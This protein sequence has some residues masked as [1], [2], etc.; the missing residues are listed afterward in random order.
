MRIGG[1]KIQGLQS[2]LQRTTGALSRALERLGTGSRIPSWRDDTALSSISTK[3]DSQVR[4]LN[5]SVQN[6]KEALALTEV[7]SSGIDQQIEIVQRMREIAVEAASSSLTQDE[8]NSLQTELQQLLGDYQRINSN[9][10]YN[11][12][13][14]LNGSKLNVGFEFSTPDTDLNSSFRINAG[15]GAFTRTS[16]LGSTGH[17]GIVVADL[18]ADGHDDL[19]EYNGRVR[20]GT[21]SGAFG[22]YQVAATFGASVTN[23]VV[24]DVTADGILDLVYAGSD[25]SAVAVGNGDGTFTD[26]LTLNATA[27]DYV[28]T[29][30]FDGDGDIDIVV[31]TTADLDNQIYLNTGAES[32]TFSIAYDLYNTGGYVDQGSYG[33]QSEDINSDGKT[34]LVYTTSSMVGFF[35]QMLTVYRLGTGQGTFGAPTV[36]NFGITGGSL[37]IGDVNND[38]RKDVVIGEDGAGYIFVQ[39]PN[40]GFT[41]IATSPSADKFE[42][43]DLNNDGLLDIAGNLSALNI[44]GGRFQNLAFDL[45][46]YDNYYA[47]T[48]LNSDGVI[49]FI[50]SDGNSMRLLQQRTSSRSALEKVDVRTAAK[51]EQLLGLLDSTLSSLQSGAASYSALHSRLD[52]Q[53]ASQSLMS[54]VFAD[55]KERMTSADL[56]LETAEVLRIQILQQAQMA[57]QAQ[58]NSSM[59]RVLALLEPLMR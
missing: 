56:A 25:Y 5:Q 1:F 4:G 21:G 42:L 41:Q 7:A 28:D 39:N 50:T 38:G 14:I 45:G 40:S 46:V 8:R 51:A 20:L 32:F 52:S 10:Q 31:G 16:T 15:T 9:A 6:A 18:N 47:Y 58:A 27:G 53:S 54:E 30:D 23:L 35:L 49:D 19:L 24:E 55:A 17:N 44:G 22:A 37:D 59:S 57:V 43:I 2:N 29:G 11:G 13:S 3:L 12:S 26:R 48:D 34:D 36:L 33:L